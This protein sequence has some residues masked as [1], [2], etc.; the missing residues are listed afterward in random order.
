MRTD[1]A[2]TTGNDGPVR[3]DAS[4]TVL[5]I[6]GVDD[7]NQQINVDIAAMLV[8]QD[9]RLQSL[10][11]CRFARSQVWVPDVVLQNSSNLRTARSNARDQVVIGAEGRV[12][13][14]QR[15][16]GDVSTYHNLRDF[17]F[18]A[19]DFTISFI[20]VE[21]SAE[22]LKFVPDQ[23]NTW[24]SDRLNISGWHVND[25]ALEEQSTK[26]REAGRTLSMLTLTISA[27]REVNYYLFRIMLPLFFVV[28]MSWVIFWV[29]PSRFEFQIGL[30]ATSM[31]TVIAFN[32]A[33]AGALPPL[34]YL[35]VLDQI[36]IWSIAMVFLAIAE[37][38]VT[39]LHVVNGRDASAHKIDRLA[40]VVFPILLIGGWATLALSGLR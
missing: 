12:S 6:L 19:H 20:P 7:V 31:L 5:D 2:P 14:R 26:L 11:G 33:V 29:P 17:P 30:G 37:A 36:L 32:L 22:T 3:V 23:A 28:A 27:E 24:L 21:T 10:E 38:L 40:R 25:L 34:G 8:W 16:F 13:Y 4:F 18:D 15:F 35:T 39:G 1:V 9:P